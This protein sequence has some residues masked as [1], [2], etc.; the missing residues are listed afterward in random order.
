MTNEIELTTVGAARLL[1]QNAARVLKEA[2]TIHDAAK[3]SII[4]AINVGMIPAPFKV[5]DCTRARAWGNSDVKMIIDKI[6]IDQMFSTIDRIDIVGTGF[7]IKKDRS[8][9]K[10][11]GKIRGTLE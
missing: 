9:S 10:I 6:V 8:P 4:S 11:R 1:L 5:G 2:K 7:I 3:D